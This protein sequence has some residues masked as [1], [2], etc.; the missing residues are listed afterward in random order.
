MVQ[1]EGAPQGLELD[2]LHYDDMNDG[3]LDYAKLY[4]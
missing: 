1:Q 3:L 4:Y 2:P